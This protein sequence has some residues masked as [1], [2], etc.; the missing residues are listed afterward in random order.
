MREIKFRGQ[1][2][3]TSEFVFGQLAYFFNNSKNTMIMPNCYF[4]TRDFGEEDENGNPKIE[5][6]IALGGYVSVNP[7]TIGQYTTLKDKNGVEIY[8]GDIISF[9]YEDK[10][11]KNGF[12]VCYGIAVFENGCF[13]AKQHNFEY[14]REKALSLNEWL[15]DEDCEVI[16][17]IYQNHELL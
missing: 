9:R 4:G 10:A 6:E 1:R 2:T 13:L 8:E 15:I 11:E 3:D 12:G 14:K 7:D 17:N 16:G 5:K